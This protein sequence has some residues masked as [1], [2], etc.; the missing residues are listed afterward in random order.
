MRQND[1]VEHD[2][3][4]EL[5]G[6][7]ANN[8]DQNNDGRTTQTM[9]AANLYTNNIPGGGSHALELLRDHFW[10]EATTS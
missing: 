6:R 3:T 8:R 5:L 4:M 1:E 7:N 2:D 10:T 9:N